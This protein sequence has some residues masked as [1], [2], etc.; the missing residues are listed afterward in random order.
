MGF[1]NNKARRA[2]WQ[3]LLQQHG[4]EKIKAALLTLPADTEKVLELHYLSGHSF[5]EI[6]TMM[7][8]SISIIRNHH[9]RGIHLL[10]RYFDTPVI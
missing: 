6:V 7:N 2:Y 5:E 3:E 9:N 1:H 10:Q 4:I 8:R